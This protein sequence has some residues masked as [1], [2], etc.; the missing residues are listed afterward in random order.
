MI[1][2]NFY[3]NMIYSV[4]MMLTGFI[5]AWSAQTIYNIYLL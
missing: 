2:Y 5:S 4:P 1:W 3:K